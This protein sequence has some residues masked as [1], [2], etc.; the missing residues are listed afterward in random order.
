MLPDDIEV[1]NSPILNP[2]TMVSKG[3]GDIRISVDAR[4]VNQFTSDY[5]RTPLINEL[6]QRFHGVPRSEL[7]LSADRVTRGISKC[8]ALMCES[9][10]NQYKRVR[11]GFRNSLPAFVRAIKITL[12]ADLEKVV[13]YVDDIL[14]HSPTMD[15]HIRHPDTV[16]GK[17]TEAGFTIN[18]KKCRF[19]RDEVKFLGHRIDK[20]GVSA[21]PDRVQSILNYP[22]Q[23]N[24]RQLRQFLGTRNF[25]SRLIIGYADYFAPL[26][27]LL[28]QSVKWT[29]TGEAQDAFLRLRQ[30]FAH[31]IHLVNQRDDAPYEIYTDT[32]KL[33]ISS[34]LTQ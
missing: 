29:W 1:T 5:E 20:T 28:N 27:P 10:V 24:S 4:R 17:L 33:G 3:G 30:S 31:S 34:I 11:Y 6:L 8:T 7:C 25:H 12:G 22:A 23:R 14:I 26:T 13:S 2:L 32:S 9:T 18:A 15:D 19:C 16:L 21:D